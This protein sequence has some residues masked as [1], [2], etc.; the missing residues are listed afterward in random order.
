MT[1]G[2]LAA[3]AYLQRA[4]AMHADADRLR[5]KQQR[6][7]LARLVVFALIVL[8]VAAAI[9]Y[10]ARRTE[11][12]VV[13]V[14]VVFSFA[15]LL[16]ASRRVGAAR[17]RALTVA[18]VNEQSAARVERQWDGVPLP[19]IASPTS[20][21]DP[22][23][24]DLAIFGPRSLAHLLPPLSRAHGA[25]LMREWLTTP[26]SSDAIVARQRSV[27]ELIAQR[28]LGE[29]LAVYALGSM[30]GADTAER[31]AAWSAAPGSRSHG[32]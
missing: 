17:A 14:I 3:A 8:V 16:A 20:D 26:T 29:S 21:D 1:R 12:L 11:W 27:R 10:P 2:S 15:R 22:L 23:Q 7:G 4:T 31:F 32:G 28:E 25:P 13:V 9:A 6:L 30:V 19:A 5:R 18:A 24:G